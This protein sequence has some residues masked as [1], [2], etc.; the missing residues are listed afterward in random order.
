MEAALAIFAKAGELYDIAPKFFNVSIPALLT[1]IAA[2][3]YGAW[4]LRGHLANT[5]KE[6]IEQRLGMAKEQYEL[7]QKQNETAKTEADAFKAE[8]I[9]L[10]SQVARGVP[11]KE[12]AT[13][14]ATLNGTVDKLIS[15]ND[16]VSSTLEAVAVT[17]EPVGR[18][19]AGLLDYISASD[20]KESSPPTK[21]LPPPDSDLN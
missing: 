9:Q 8:L 15:A 3:I 16:A 20:V 1:A 19:V 21:A 12:I 4:W 2:L 6:I 17:L 5:Q 11:L 14:T 13:S 18:W 7:A 10:K